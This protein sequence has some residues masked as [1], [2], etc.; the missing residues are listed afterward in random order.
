MNVNPFLIFR[1]FT[2]LAILIIVILHY[3]ITKILKIDIYFSILSISLLILNPYLVRYFLAVPTM[4][5]DVFFIL[6]IYLFLLAMMT[7]KNYMLFGVTLS[8]ISRQNGIFLFIS[9]I[10]YRIIDNKHKFFKD[11]N[12]IFSFF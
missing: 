3:L 8:L 2:Y 1:I 7:K 4:V 6:S 5:N 12:L 10:F 11:K 9:H